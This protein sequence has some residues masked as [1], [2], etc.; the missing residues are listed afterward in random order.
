MENDKYG[1]PIKADVEFGRVWGFGTNVD[2]DSIDE[3]VEKIKEIY[4]VV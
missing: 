3:S 2:F 4:K 1:L